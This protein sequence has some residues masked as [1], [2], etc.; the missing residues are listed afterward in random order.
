MIEVVPPWAPD[1][2]APCCPTVIMA[3]IPLMTD[4]FPTTAPAPEAPP[5]VS[6]L[7]VPPAPIR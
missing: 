2:A 3:G 5:E 4:N 1:A 6:L 7:E